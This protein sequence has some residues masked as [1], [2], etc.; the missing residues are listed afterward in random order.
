[1][2]RAIA[3]GAALPIA[4]VLLSGCVGP[5]TTDAAYRGKAV[6]AADA[7]QSAVQTAVLTSKGQLAGKILGAYAE[8]VLSNAEDS[9]SSVQNSFDSIQPPDD[10]KSDK[11]RNGLD[12]LL[13]SASSDLSDLRIA[14]RRDD[15]AKMASVAQDLAA[16]APKLDAF[17]QEHS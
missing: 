7:A 5:A 10:S 9:M 16:L 14:A 1:M 11:L 15:S 4:A 3:L 6:H 2:T 8:T 17:S 13:T 12:S